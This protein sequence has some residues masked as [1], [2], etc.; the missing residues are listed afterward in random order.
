MKQTDSNIQGQPRPINTVE[1]DNSTMNSL[2]ATLLSNSD[3]IPYV[4]WNTDE[5][6][7]FIWNGTVFTNINNIP[8]LVQV[9]TNG[10]DAQGILIQ[11]NGGGGYLVGTLDGLGAVDVKLR[12]TGTMTLET[13]KGII[14]FKGSLDTLRHDI[15]A[16]DGTAASSPVVAIWQNKSIIVA[17]LDDITNALADYLK[18]DGSTPMNGNLDMVLHKILCETI[19]S[20][21]N[22]Y[23]QFENGDGNN[24]RFDLSALSANRDFILPNTSGT[25]ALTSDLATYLPLSGG[26]MGGDINMQ[27]HKLVFTSYNGQIQSGGRLLLTDGVKSMG[28][29]F[30]AVTGSKN[31]M[32]QD[33]SGTI[34]L[35]SDIT[36]SLADYLKLDG[37]TPMTGDLDMQTNAVK[38]NEIKT[39]A[40]RLNWLAGLDS[41]IHDFT[42][43]VG[44]GGGN[45]TQIWRPKQGTVAHL[46][47]IKYPYQ[48]AASDEVT[49]LIADPSQA[50]YTDYMAYELTVNSVMI[51]VNTA[52]TGDDG[53]IVDIKKNGTTIFTTPISI[54]A[55]ENTS[56]TASVPYV[57][58]GNITFA[59][60]DKIEAFITQ[61]GSTV[62][63]AGL[64]I[65]LL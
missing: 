34:A 5:L 19:V 3:T 16:L 35:L 63:G 58:N 37:T 55:T 6:S 39:A 25:I 65:K 26:T 42:S 54:D 15:T 48:F 59:V 52:P 23:I 14:D 20:A 62:A 44:G 60:G 11:L 47:D 24:A 41:L 40:G 61:V 29:E 8:T 2:A 46:D 21:Y 50:A 17:G 7:Y 12:A 13:S 1:V 9:L 22:D 33:A 57:L 28:L 18:L 31:I 32:F 56:L 10:N 30:S 45:F 4:V 27:F 38:T 49:P 53:I 43:W 36:S 51:N 64:K